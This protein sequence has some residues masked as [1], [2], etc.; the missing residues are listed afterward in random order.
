MQVTAQVNYYGSKIAGPIYFVQ[1]ALQYFLENAKIPIYFGNKPVSLMQFLP[2]CHQG[3][4]I[5]ST[6]QLLMMIYVLI[7]NLTVLT[8]GIVAYND[9]SEL[10]VIPDELMNIAFN[11]SIPAYYADYIYENEI[12]M[13]EAVDDR[14]IP[15]YPD[16]YLNTLEVIQRR[17]P[18]FN[19][20]MFELQFCTPISEINSQRRLPLDLQLYYKSPDF[21]NAVGKEFLIVTDM[22][23]IL[24]NMIASEL[25]TTGSL[26]KIEKITDIDIMEHPNQTNLLEAILA[27]NRSNKLAYAIINNNLNDVKRYINAYDPRD[28]NLEV[29]HLAVSHNPTLINYD[30]TTGNL[31]VRHLEV[32]RE[33]PE[34]INLI[35]KAIIERNALEQRT[36]QSM[37]VPLGESD[38]PQTE[39]FRQYG[40]SLLK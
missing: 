26:L 15:D 35:E 21:L 12:T 25:R 7:N 34:I 3:Y 17:D 39:M 30:A 36:F 16:H 32:S 24:T 29:Y 23:V 14:M 31:E 2:L 40:R 1:T 10:S 5:D 37:M 27:D 22:Y 28:N 4:A 20:A 33:N 8:P 11:G 9:I 18:N 38:I 19:P 6:L 13:K